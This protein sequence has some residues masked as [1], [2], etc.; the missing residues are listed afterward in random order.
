L[1]QKTNLDNGIRVVTEFIPYVRSV[2]I[3]FWFHA[4][5]RDE[6]LSNNGISHFIEHMVFKGTARRTARQIAE[7]IDAAGGQLNAF[8]SKEHTCYYARVLDEQL[9]LAVEILADMVMSSSFNSSDVEK[10]KGVIL[11]EIRMY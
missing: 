8:T 11:E 2:T 1:Y 3:G 6:D 4:G 5:S 9:E 10:E 7:T